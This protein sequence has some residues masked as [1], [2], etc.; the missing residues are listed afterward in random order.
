MSVL[1]RWCHRRRL[2]VVLS[3]LGVLIGLT[4]LAISAGSNFV[5]SPTLPNTESGTA[6]ALLQRNAPSSAGTSG[7][8]VWR[9]DGGTVTDNPVEARMAG[10]LQQ[11]SRSSGVAYVV[12]P[13]SAGG[14]AQISKDGKIAYA[15]VNFTQ[16]GAALSDADVTR[17]QDL[18]TAARQSGLDVQLGG[19]AFTKEKLA[20]G[21][22]EIV[23]VLTAGI[24]LLLVMR[25]LWAAALPI[26]TAVTGVGSAALTVI[27]LSHAMTLSPTTPTL[28]A[29]IGLGVGI[30][31]AL[32]IVNRHRHNLMAGM[33]V[34]DSIAK[35]MDTSGRAVVFAGLT[36]VIALLGMFTLGLSLLSGMALGAA[37]TVVMT[38][39]SAITLLPALLGMLGL[40]VL[41]RKQRRRLVSGEADLR[42]RVGLWARW[43]ALVQAR[44]KALGG[45]ALV[46]MA[47]VAVPTF[48]MRLGAADNG[49]LPS[50][51]T[52]RQAYDLV[53]QGFGPGFNGPLLLV[54]QA[55]TAADKAALTRLVTELKTTA[56]VASAGA[57]PV[58]RSGDVEVVT[59]VPTTSPQAAATADLITQLHQ[60]VIPPI[61]AGTSLHVYVGGPTAINDDFATVLLGKLPLFLLVIAALGFLLLTIAFRS[62]LIPAL[63][64][65]LNLLTIGAAFGAIVIVFQHGI[66]SNLL[67][68]GSAGPIEAFVP[69]LVVGVMFGLSMDYQV[70]LVSRM[71]EEWAHT[72]D[73]HRAVRV[74]Q[75]ET[76]QVIAVAASIMFFVF[77]SFA[78]GGGRVIS[79]FGFGLAVAAVLDAF[80]VRMVLV[81][82]VMHLCGPANWW[83][84]RRLDRA[85]P[86]VS[87]DGPAQDTGQ[88]RHPNA[89][90]SCTAA[91]IADQ[92]SVC[93]WNGDNFGLDHDHPGAQAY[94]DSLFAQFAAWGVDFVKADDMLY[95]YHAREIAALSKAM[96]DCGRPMTLSLSPGRAMSLEYAGHLREHADMWRVADDLWDRWGDVRAQFDRLAMWAPYAG[97]GSWPDADMLPLGRIGI[98]A[99]VGPER[100][101]RLTWDEQR[102][103]MTLWCIARSPL[104]F[105][106]DLPRTDEQTLGLLTN[107]DV[108][109]VLSESSNNRQ[110]LR[111]HELVLWTAD[112]TGVPGRYVAVFNT[113]ETPISLDS[114]WFAVGC[115]PGGRVV[116]LWEQKELPE[117]SDR[118]IADVP[119]HGSLLLRTEP[120]G[121]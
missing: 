54:A 113:G 15:T 36:V 94:Y 55:P 76:G 31:Y 62:L 88:P 65:V 99:E 86:H 67:G 69:I 17:V 71:R 18:A 42:V 38:V 84:P 111:D 58:D 51:S 120:G 74:G 95:P 100:D 101:S 26:V 119:P 82:A 61:E 4:F 33:S 107:A 92:N 19:S 48:S 96:R 9:V 10:A 29:L 59:V 112:R 35:A 30:D 2:A 80:I 22:S 57:E 63:G 50:T 20:S 78:T 52:N 72:G 46:V 66:G 45:L 68:V 37:V 106:G 32:F 85:L 16:S 8:V 79:E 41:S 6:I 5:D 90:T 121:A 23:G 105:G 115:V 89:A 70:F 11:I 21:T 64:A 109:A 7:M 27:L 83:L 110:V 25:S 103:L 47:V 3:W 13:Y 102:T 81:P 114:A 14:S 93:A 56:G 24:I 91:Q 40:R 60:E 87:V 104:M 28:G 43:A 39:L 53:A 97:P 77:G 73:N 117:L 98:R 34:A 108:L 116:D 12:S 1:A 118:L 49:N 44:P 75:G